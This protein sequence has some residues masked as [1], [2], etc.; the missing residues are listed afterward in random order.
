M[1]LPDLSDVDGSPGTVETNTGSSGS[2]RDTRNSPPK[3]PVQEAA[4][5]IVR[6]IEVHD[7]FWLW[8]EADIGVA[9]AD[10]E[11]YDDRVSDVVAALKEA[12]VETLSV[13]DFFDF[14]LEKDGYEFIGQQPTEYLENLTDKQKELYSE[15]ELH[16]Y[17][18]TEKPLRNQVTHPEYLEEWRDGQFDS[19]SHSDMTGLL[20]AYYWPEVYAAF[21]N[22]A[23]NPP[24]V[25]VGIDTKGNTQ[26]EYPDA[27]EAVRRKRSRFRI[28][29]TD[30]AFPRVLKS[31]VSH[32]TLS[33]S[34]KEQFM[35][36]HVYTAEEA[37]NNEDATEGAVKPDVPD[38]VLEA[39]A[40]EVKSNR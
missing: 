23:N 20:N 26:S 6:M 12:D 22:R 17:G 30:K 36:E 13:E 19:S 38:D 15:E 10:Y 16:Q 4:D 32:G 34:T 31:M 21:K 27:F 9:V 35:K 5:Y 33:S 3:R 39:I 40:E 7:G 11:N 28:T 14:S 18:D 29:T 25:K 1:E 2:G 8:N 37:E 24:R